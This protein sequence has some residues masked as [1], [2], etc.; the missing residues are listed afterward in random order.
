[1]MDQQR[2]GGGQGAG[3]GDSLYGEDCLEKAVC[4]WQTAS[5][6]GDQERLVGVS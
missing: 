2:S 3:G 1:M 4:E 5:E 6:D